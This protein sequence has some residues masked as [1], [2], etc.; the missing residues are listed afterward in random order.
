MIPLS[1]E[2]RMVLE[3]YQEIMSRPEV[4]ELAKENSTSG[5]MNGVL[6]NISSGKGGRAW[7]EGEWQLEELDALCQS[8][9][10]YVLVNDGHPDDFIKAMLRSGEVTEPE[11][12]NPA[13]PTAPPIT[14][15]KGP[16]DQPV[17][18]TFHKFSAG[19]IHIRFPIPRQIQTADSVTITANLL[20]SE[21]IMTLISLISAINHI[22][23]GIHIELVLPYLPYSRQDRVCCEGEDFGLLTFLRMLD[24]TLS[25]GGCWRIV[26]WDVHSKVAEKILD[27]LGWST[28]HVF[29]NIEAWEL[30]G[31]SK[32]NLN[33][34][35]IVA[36]DAGAVERAR[37]VVEV[38]NIGQQVVHMTKSRDPETGY[39][40]RFGIADKDIDSWD[41]SLP[42][43]LV[44]DICDGGRTFIGAAN[45]LRSAGFYGPISL[46]VT[47][48]IF[49][50]GFTELLNHFDEIIVA[51]VLTDQ[52]L[53]PRVTKLE[54]V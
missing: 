18:W 29:R 42:V 8:I 33:Y 19:E 44:D 49:S 14:I 21:S 51:N 41:K 28:H 32:F 5:R 36:P 2:D 10:Q 31:Q 39:L 24:S 34:H 12:N 13:G 1:K 40:S 7:L 45:A 15:I 46:Y 54:R 16:D 20:T 43:L 11:N 37:A 22:K 23:S 35:Y 53:P 48:G 27:D 26:T 4:A 6:E 52:P 9:R 30:L 25:Y 3:R 17:D 50:A 38:A 47:H